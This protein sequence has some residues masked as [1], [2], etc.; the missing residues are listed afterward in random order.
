MPLLNHTPIDY[1]SWDLDGTGN[2]IFGLLNLVEREVWK[3][4]LPYQ[5]KRNDTGHAEN[6]TYFALNLLNY[7]PTDKKSAREVVIPSAILHDTGWSQLTEI[8][9]KL[10]YE[11]TDDGIGKKIWERYEPV[12][13]ARHQEQGVCLSKKLLNELNYPLELTSQIL[14]IIYQHDT[15]KEFLNE[16]DGIMKDADK[17]WRYT[18]PH[19]RLGIRERNL[20]PDEFSNLLFSNV[21]KEGF[22]YS[23]IS[24][25]IAEIELKNTLDYW[26]QKQD[27]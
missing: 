5:D 26:K 18:L 23:P 20:N 24:R 27:N 21:N 12:L 2:N 16:N 1:N 4:S 11:C 15:G 22:F 19:F 10:F 7:I 25:E 13:R 6:V 9:R 8:E 17:L 14:E 3:K